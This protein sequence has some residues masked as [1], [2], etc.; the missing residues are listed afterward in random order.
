MSVIVV[1]PDVHDDLLV[2]LFCEEGT[3]DAVV[4]SN[5]LDVLFLLITLLLESLNLK[6]LKFAHE[7]FMGFLRSL[8]FRLPI[9]LELIRIEKC[10]ITLRRKWASK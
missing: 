10:L 9:C 6:S 2:P 4:V 3:Q 1:V 8:I 5:V 7:K